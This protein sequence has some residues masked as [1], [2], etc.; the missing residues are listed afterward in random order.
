MLDTNDDR[1]NTYLPYARELIT[2]F[3]QRCEAIYGNTFVVY[4]VHNLLHLPDDAEF[5]K[6]SLNDISCFPFKNYMQQLKR[7]VRNAQNPLVQVVKRLEELNRSNGA[8]APFDWRFTSISSKLKDSCFLLPNSKYAFVVETK[9][10]VCDVISNRHTEKFQ[11]IQNFLTLFMCEMCNKRQ[12]GVWLK[13]LKFSPKLY[14]FHTRKDLPYSHYI[15]K[16]KDAVSSVPWDELFGSRKDEKKKV[17]L[18]LV[19]GQNSKVAKGN[20]C[21][22]RSEQPRKTI[23]GLAHLPTHKS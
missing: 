12:S 9:D 5:F 23:R 1:H 22:E 7:L 3:V 10:V 20:H 14:A 8:D 4:N 6:T 13:S 11:P 15:M 16:S 21:H 2:H 17:S 18:S 19:G